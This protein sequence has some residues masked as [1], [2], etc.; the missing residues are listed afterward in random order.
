MPN[1][2]VFLLGAG[3][4]SPFGIPMMAGFYAAFRKYLAAR[5]PHCFALLERLER[6]GRHPTQDL[7]T[8]LSDLNAVAGLSIGLGLLGAAAAEH[9]ED[10][11]LARELRGY[12]D[13]FI[14]DTCE[15]FDQ[16][17]SVR[18][19]QPLLALRDLGP[20]W[21]FTT[22]Y[23]RIVEYACE[24]SEISWTDGFEHPG[25]QAVADWTGAFDTEVRI[26]KLHGS[27][28]WYVDDPDGKL[29]RLDR[30][31][32][33]P[34]YDFAL[35]RQEQRLRPLMIIP[36]LEKEALGT[37]Y[38]ELSVRFTDALS[39]SRLLIIAGN[40]LRDRHIR[41][42][43]RARA[44]TLQILVVSPSATQRRAI[45][46]LPERIHTLDAGFTEFLAV[47]G[48]RL[49]ELGRNLAPLTPGDPG[50]H[51]AVETF[52]ASISQDTLDETALQKDTDLYRLWSALRSSVTTERIRAIRELASHTH[53]ALARRLQR[54]MEQDPEEH[55]RV[56]CV[57]AL[58]QA[59]GDGSVAPLCDSL[60]RELS[61]P[62][63]LELALALCRRSSDQQARNGLL[64][65]LTRP[66]LSSVARSVIQEHV[67]NR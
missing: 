24:Q 3:A 43:V 2:I 18:E 49:A 48:V 64:H 56:A 57:A 55:V 38:V 4:S 7:E 29:H 54:L 41:D 66:E 30:G 27:V 21:V 19:L 47:G 53:P 52:I 39:E 36:T 11:K 10:V 58:C 40:S 32:S 67:S 60:S 23:D 31:Y 45:L 13:A 28:N 8:L 46:G 34:A 17:A 65:A 22:N 6:S 63:Q 1:P 37:P 26:V 16:A 59:A 50:N 42:Y 61:A 25:G 9:E 12:L 44:G 14:V 35:V 20:L 62:V 15:R 51:G 5:H 33:L